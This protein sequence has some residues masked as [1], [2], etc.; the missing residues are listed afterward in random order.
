MKPAKFYPL[1]R[2]HHFYS[3]LLLFAIA[4]RLCYQL[5]FLTESVHNLLGL[6]TDDFFYYL[7]IS[8][9]I[10]SGLG[11][12]FDGETATNG[13]HPL[14]MAIVYCFSWIPSLELRAKICLAL[15]MLFDAISCVLIYRI[16]LLLVKRHW[17]LL[18]AL[19]LIACK[20]HALISLH[21][22][23]TPLAT[24]ILG[25]ALL[26]GIR[27]LNTNQL[28][29]TSTVSLGIT[30]GL[31][32][33]ARTDVIIL[34]IP[35]VFALF[36]RKVFSRAF[37]WFWI[38]LILTL[39]PWILWNQVLFDSIFQ[40]SAK[41][42]AYR[43]WTLTMWLL[44]QSHES[45]LWHQMKSMGGAILYVLGS[46]HQAMPW[47]VLLILILA[48]L[49][50]KQHESI[51]QLQEDVGLRLACFLFPAILMMSLG[52]GFFGQFQHWYL[53]SLIWLLVLSVT[54]CV[55]RLS[56][57]ISYIKQGAIGF[58]LLV[59]VIIGSLNTGSM[60]YPMMR[61][62][63]S[64]L[65]FIKNE[66]DPKDRIGIFSA[67]YYKYFLPNR[68]IINLDGAVNNSILPALKTRK[69]YDYLKKAK[70]DYIVDYQ[71]SCKNIFR[72]FGAGPLQNHLKPIA[73]LKDRNPHWNV[74]VLGV[75]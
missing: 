64:T 16:L 49:N 40:S 18:G 29:R 51:I 56:L 19:F 30:I 57:K 41:T 47:V 2:S 3:G 20:D 4:I 27:M 42:H 14:W 58:T 38:A 67:G 36:W 75:R 37:S 65:S 33:L 54:I 61:V 25:F 70:L 55:D 23:E 72:L 22:L 34:A 50:R 46:L 63:R 13:F 26:L 31:C 7:A 66:L 69:L 71:V 39:I 45:V 62:N 17:A 10:F 35:M 48:M 12:T 11:V 21:G 15:L 52:Y 9:N 24:M 43:E 28:S 44:E 32:C 68:Q 53:H 73:V 6:V 74:W 59:L 8:Q 60:Y 5:S 1:K